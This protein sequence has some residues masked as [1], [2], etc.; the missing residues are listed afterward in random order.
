MRRDSAGRAGSSATCVVP[1][2]A[3]RGSVAVARRAVWCGAVSD[4]LQLVLALAAAV[5]AGAIN[6]L[7]GGGSLV[8]FPVLVALGVPP[9]VANVTNT[10]ALSPGYLSATVAQARDLAGQCRRAIALVAAGAVGGLAGGVLLLRTGD[11]L[12]GELVPFLLLLASGLLAAQNRVRAWL[13]RGAGAPHAEAWAIPLVAAA[14]VYGGYFG[15]GVSVMIL[16]VLGVVLHDTLTRLNA[17]KQAISF[18][19][20]TTAAIFFAF[21]GHVLWPTAA[22]MAVGALLGGLVGGR[23]AGRIP[24]GVLRAIVVTVGVVVAVV[25]LVRSYVL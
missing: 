12:F 18:A 23:L 7:A 6:A 19:T 3:A 2:R 25:Y 1:A 14:A 17:L 4:P 15:A 16:A 21:S 11:A 20:N 9:V 8:T 24:P 22:A 13:T 5:A 10:V